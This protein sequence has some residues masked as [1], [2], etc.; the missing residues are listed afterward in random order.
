[1]T[2][3]TARAEE[4]RTVWKAVL[5]RYHEDRDTPLNGDYWSEKDTWSRDKIRAVQDEKIAAVA[6]FL[7]E[8]SDFYRRRFDKLG[9]AP[10]DLKDVDSMIAN[11]PVVTKQEMMEDAEAHPPYGTYTTCG[12]AEW[13][14][15][16]WML[17]SSS[18]ST[19]TPRVFRYTH[20]D[21]QYW[22]Q[23]NARALYSGGLR[24]GDTGLPMT[25]FGPHVFAWG[26]QYTLAK[27][28]LPVVP[29]GGMDGHARASLIERFNPTT[30]I[31]TPSY[32]LYLGRVMQDLG[33]DPAKTSVKWLVTGGEPFSGVSGT[34]ERIQDLWGAKSLE[35]Y[36]CTEASPHCGGYSCPEYQEGDEPFIHL[37]E[38][39]QVWE[40]VDPDGLTPVGEGERGLTVCTNLNSESSAQLRFLV[41]DYTRLSHEP[42]ACG[43]N[44]VRGM[45]CLTGRSDDL[46]NLRGIK[47]FPVQIEEA[48]RAYPNTGD[49][50]QIRLTTKDDGLDVMTVVVEH[51]DGSV[52]DGVAKAI[53]SHCEIRCAVEVVGP[54][55]LPKSEMKAK[56]VFDERNK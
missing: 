56:R 50:F 49:E 30:L 38:D 19:G 21:R 55:T 23:A 13:G 52:A 6:P 24:K 51:P 29:G 31:C 44:H 53:R 14:D 47:F 2:H 26:V 54:N 40:T 25:G 34:L 11:W 43:R 10:S 36:G 22:E 45:G 16:G 41:G 37:M 15:R 28:G 8:N 1:M 3:P 27:M 32:L 4:T 5:E 33:K 42:C 7:Y 46:I 17:F 12:E 18:G 48:V 20:F 39:I 9:V 35:F